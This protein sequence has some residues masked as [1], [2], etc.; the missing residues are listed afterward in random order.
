MTSK[1]VVCH[2]RHTS[3]LFLSAPLWVRVSDDNKPV[4]SITYIVGNNRYDRGQGEQTA[5]HYFGKHHCAKRKVVV[6]ETEQYGPDEDVV[7]GAAL[8]LGV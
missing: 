7:F 1:V 5:E 8:V 6:R 4:Q 2:R 3:F